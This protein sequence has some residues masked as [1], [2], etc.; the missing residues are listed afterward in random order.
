MKLF[1]SLTYALVVAALFS[2]GCA[3]KQTH[4]GPAHSAALEIK[5]NLATLPETVTSFGAVS[6]AGWLYVFGG[7]RG[8][9]HEYS[10]EMVSG[11]FYRLNLSEGRAWEQ[12]PDA[13]PAQ[14]VP[15]VARGGSIYRLGG[16]AAR[17]AADAKQD[18]YSMALVQRFQPAHGQWETLAPLPVPRSSH[19]AVVLGEKIYVAG[20]W[21]MMGGTNKAVWP[22]DALVLDL[23]NLRAGWQSF[24]QP[25]QRRALA[26][27]ALGSRVYCIGGMDS[28]NQ[29]TLAV[30]IFDTTTRQWSKGP[31][32]PP[33]KFKGF[34]CSAIA[35][36]GRIY[37]NAF[38]G[39]LLRLATD[40]KSWEVVGRLQHPRMAHRLV[41]A[42]TT[43]LI[44]L[45]GEDGEEKRTDLEVLT[46]ALIGRAV[47]SAAAA[48]QTNNPHAP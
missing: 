3:T 19:D 28:D 22:A 24:P 11:K 30:D 18:L 20:G 32:L 21:Q 46:P 29:P 12:L 1:I 33:G 7:H 40:G 35:Q 36:D 43:Q 16:M 27:A 41:T 5:T 17:N 14:G 47:S 15:L 25:F 34:S 4:P 48:T 10:K 26:L 2:T 6:D 44:A 8:E 45:G 39:D 9:R 31:A 23:K 42:G 13:A 38:Q 37:A